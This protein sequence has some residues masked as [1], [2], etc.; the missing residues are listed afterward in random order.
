[1]G[2][3]SWS[4]G[5]V[6]ELPRIRYV[7]IGEESIAYR[8]LGGDGIPIVYLGTFGLHQD[9]M[10]EEPG[11][12]HFLRSLGSF[13]RLVTFD[14][15]GSGL[16]SRTVRP[17][18]EVRVDDLDVVLDATGIDQAVLVAATGSTLT[19]LAFGAMRPVRTRALVLYSATARQTA[20]PGYE[21]GADEGLIPLLIDG[22]ESTWGTGITGYLYA[23]S[24]ADDPQ[25]IEWCARLERS[26][27]TPLEA[28]QWI[29][30]YSE[31]NVRDV[32]PL[33]RAPSLVVT[34]TLVGGPA[35]LLSRYVADHLP[36]VRTVEIAARDEYP[37]GDGADAVGGHKTVPGRCRR[38]GAPRIDPPSP[39]CSSPTWSP[40]PGRSS[41]RGTRRGA[42]PWTPTMIW[43][44][45]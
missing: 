39:R 10:W 42:P 7:N 14:R 29:E 40:P 31:T 9:L 30:M 38:V 6:K 36:D 3:G 22:T 32:L 19:A 26:V 11:Y 28:R 24:L 4:D 8:D 12:A 41:P 15:R 21:I 27:A 1:M 17:T 35:P 44:G 33:V 18:I 34:P 2:S 45:G 5:G 37:F 25:F 13:G 16:S 23:P 43:F 20:A